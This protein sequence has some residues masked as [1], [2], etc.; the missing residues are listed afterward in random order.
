MFEDLAAFYGLRPSVEHKV[1]W[2]HFDNASGQ[3]QQLAGSLTLELPIEAQQAAT[4]EYF[5]SVIDAEN[6]E[7][8]SVT[9]YIRKA[10]DGYDVVGVE[11]L[12]PHIEQPEI[13][14]CPN[15]SQQF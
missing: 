3:K 5:S 12:W 7:L 4:G 15:R 11:R 9:V 6:T 1:H 10:D 2:F 13:Q 8:K 14:K